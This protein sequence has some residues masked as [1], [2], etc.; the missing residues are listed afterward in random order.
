M[1]RQT[2]ENDVHETVPF[3]STFTGYIIGSEGRGIQN[4]KMRSG[5]TKIWVDNKTQVHFRDNWSYL[6]VVGTPMNNDAA[7]CLL[8][9]RIRDA[10]TRTAPEGREYQRDSHRHHNDE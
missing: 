4:L 6:H 7:K 2:G 10:S 1:Q 8:M 9:Q 5:V 3:L